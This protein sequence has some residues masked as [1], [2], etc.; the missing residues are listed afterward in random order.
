MA[1]GLVA[2]PVYSYKILHTVGGMGVGCVAPDGII[3]TLWLVP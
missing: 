3:F 2:G 1:T